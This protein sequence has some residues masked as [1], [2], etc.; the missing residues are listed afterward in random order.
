MEYNFNEIEQK[1]QQYWKE[2]DTYKVGID[3]WQT[4]VL[5]A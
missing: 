2:K 3:H 1:W 4:Q 5:C